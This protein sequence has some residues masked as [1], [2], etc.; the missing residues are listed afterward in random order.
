MQDE[1]TVAPREPAQTEAEKELGREVTR[2]LIFRPFDRSIWWVVGVAPPYFA[3]KV[4]GLHWQVTVA[5]C[6]GLAFFAFGCS[7]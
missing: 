7:R 3:Y 2:T 6:S 4:W 1:S 5:A